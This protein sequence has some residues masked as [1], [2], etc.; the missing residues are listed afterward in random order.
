MGSL[1]EL[2]GRNFHFRAL[3]RHE[4]SGYQLPLPVLYSILMHTLDL[5]KRWRSATEM[6]SKSI[7]FKNKFS[8]RTFH[9]VIKFCAAVC[10]RER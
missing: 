7:P 5:M 4:S 6:L 8:K 3:K 1:A 2:A 9:S 10:K